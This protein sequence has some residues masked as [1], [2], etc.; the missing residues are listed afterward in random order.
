M[1][2]HYKDG[3][4]PEADHLKKELRAVPF[5]AT[6][7]K[8]SKAEQLTQYNSLMI[9]DFDNLGPK[10]EQVKKENRR[11]SLYNGLFYKSEGK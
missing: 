8:G 3:M 5:S 9:F 4:K 7:D 6:F 11:M 1:R 2:K 10:L